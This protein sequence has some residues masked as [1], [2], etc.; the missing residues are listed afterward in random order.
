MKIAII[1]KKTSFVSG[2]TAVV[3]ICESENVLP[4]LQSISG[5]ALNCKIEL[6]T[7]DDKVENHDFSNAWV[8]DNIEFEGECPISYAFLT[9]ILNH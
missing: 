3:A 5:D 2:F 6:A 9:T 8:G 4:I 1:I 7:V